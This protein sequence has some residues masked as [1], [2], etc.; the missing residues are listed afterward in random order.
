MVLWMLLGGRLSITMS[1][2]ALEGVFR[3]SMA[4]LGATLDQ[5][6]LVEGSLGIGCVHSAVLRSYLSSDHVQ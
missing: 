3:F 5:M 6:S 2:S 4:A 1:T